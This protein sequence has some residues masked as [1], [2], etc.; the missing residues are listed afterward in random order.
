M[1]SHA[2]TSNATAGE[3]WSDRKKIVVTLSILAGVIVT[4]IFLYFCGQFSWW[5]P[6]WRAASR[7]DA[8]N[9]NIMESRE[10]KV[11]NTA[12]F[13]EATRLHHEAQVEFAHN[14]ELIH[15]Y[16][17]NCPDLFRVHNNGDRYTMVLSNCKNGTDIQFR[18]K[19][20]LRPTVWKVQLYYFGK[21]EPKT[22]LE[23][24]AG[25][26]LNNVPTDPVIKVLNEAE[27]DGSQVK[28]IAS[29]VF[30]WTGFT[31]LVYQG[32][33]DFVEITRQ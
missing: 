3:K 5:Q 19:N 33:A 20:A 2:T 28:K 11:H 4:I 27:D 25:H 18:L 8:R 1:S 22:G 26:Q 17:Q 32:N 10:R 13:E 14:H 21:G 16:H 31:K 6:N 29:H 9:N 15:D 7:L 30:E 24:E 12:D 23:K